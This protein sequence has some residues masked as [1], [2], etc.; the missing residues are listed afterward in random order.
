MRPGFVQSAERLERLPTDLTHWEIGPFHPAVPGPLKLRL[1]L[2]GEIIAKLSYET[3]FAFRALEKRFEMRP[4]RSGLPYADRLDPET[5]IFGQVA[6][7]LA[8]ESLMGLETPKRAQQVRAVL[9]E[10]ARISAHFR[11]FVQVAKSVA[12]DTFMHYALRDREKILDLFEL[13]TG[14]RFTLN[15]LRFGGVAQDVTEGFL[16]RVADV[17]D[18]LRARMKEYNDLFSFNDAF[19]GRVCGTGIV[20]QEVA[21]KH[22]LTGPNARGAGLSLDVRK[23]HPYLVYGQ[24]DF[25]VPLGRGEFGVTGDVHDRFLVR[26]RE[27]LQSIEIVKQVCESMADGPHQL[28]GPMDPLP[29]RAGEGFSRVESPR[30]L[31]ACYVASDGGNGPARVQFVPPSVAAL[32]ALPEL[33]QGACLEDLPVILAS[34]DLSVAEVDR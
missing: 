22:G 1:T 31:L 2:D 3:G 9:C 18:L 15:F 32:S 30:G 7:C 14:A 10:L 16:E 17:C 8:A 6:Y 29:T 34:L 27:I 4:W 12:A 26:L 28:L 5:A 13:I 23:A 24:T 33:A 21:I 25:E 20:T 11:G 19:L